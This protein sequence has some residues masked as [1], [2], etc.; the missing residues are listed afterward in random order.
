[1]MIYAWQEQEWQQLKKLASTD[2]IPHA[3][4]FAGIKGVGKL[5]LAENFARLALCQQPNLFA[6]ECGTCHSCRLF[7]TKAHPDALWLEP[8]KEGANIKIDQI[9]AL[10]DFISQSALQGKYRT[11]IINPANSMNLNAA[12]ALLKTLEEPTPNAI[13]ILVSDQMAQLPPT[14][15]S[16]CHKIQC[17]KPA[18]TLAIA[19][20][21]TQL[22]DPVD[23]LNLLLNLANGAPLTALRLANDDVLPMRQTLVKAIYHTVLQK[24][25]PIK[26]A[27]SLQEIDLLVFIDYALSLIGDV[28]R[29]QVGD[30]Q[31]VNQDIKT[32]INEITEASQLKNNVRLMAELQ[33]IRSK[34]CLGYHVNKQL[35]I[36][37]F[38]IGLF[39][40]S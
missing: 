39:K 26:T 13:I 1:M 15:L 18:N 25:D 24:A 6:T 10:T 38:L 2:R 16:R 5:T 17:P 33:S 32:E 23:K 36:E 35:W 20:L 7:L 27:A 29:L 19:W 14:I 8:E 9:R 3:M 12:N 28:L 34:I 37:Q 4:I 31:I 21:Q 40:C 11:V 22:K 30:N